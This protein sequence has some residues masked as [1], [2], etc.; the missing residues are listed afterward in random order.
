MNKATKIVFTGGGSG[1][2][3]TPLIAVAREI[4]R[5]HPKDDVSI[6]YIGPKDEVGSILLG[7]ENIQPRH[8]TSGK[9]RG[10][11]SFQNVTDVALKIP[12]GF[13]QSIFLLISLRPSLVF[14]KGGTGSISVTVA[15]RLLRIPVFL[16]ESDIVPGKS[17]QMTSRWAKKIFI[18]FEKT[19]FFYL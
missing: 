6:F 1:G 11:F 18:S 16:H 7:Q 12:F 14:S 13:L 10:Y 8:I 3:L 5:L 4:R 9:L 17:N 2:H 15:A 19:E